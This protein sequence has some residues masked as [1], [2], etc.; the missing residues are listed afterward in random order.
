MPPR[1][2][3]AAK[4]EPVKNK[5]PAAAP[6]KKKTT[7]VAKA[8]PVRKKK[9]AEA[10]PTSVVP[11][12]AAVAGR[13]LVIVES[14]AKAKTIEKYLGRGFKVL[15]SYGHVRDLPPKGKQRGED[16]VGIT[17][18]EGWKPRYVVVDRGAKSG[19]RKFKSAQ[20]ILDELKKEADKSSVVYLA[21]DPDREGESIAWH[22]ADELKLDPKRTRRIAFN[23][24]TKTA[25]QR[26]L[27][28]PSSINDQLV[29]AQEA[30]RVL[31]RV[32]GY[33]LSNLLGKKVTRGLSA[34]RVQSVAVKLIV[35]REREIEA[36]KSEEYWKITALLSLPGTVSYTAD[37]AKAKV[38]A[39]KKG[40][41]LKKDEGKE[42]LEGEGDAPKKETAPK[43][44]AGSFLA[45]LTRWNGQE[46]AASTEEQV[47]GIYAALN[48]AA[49]VVTKVDQK[50][51]QRRAP[52]P[53]TTSTLQQSG[54]QR[55]GLSSKHTM[56]LAQELYQGVNLGSEGS[57]ALITYMRTDSTRVSADALTM[58]RDYIKT[59]YGDRYLPDKP[60]FFKSGKSAQEAHEAIRP[61]DLS[62]TPA[63]VQPY[64]SP[65]QYKLYTL[66]FNQFVAS[67]MMPAIVAVTS[68]DIEAA[69]GVLRASG[70]IEKFDGWRK[71]NP[72]AKQEDKIL[73]PLAEKQALEKLDLTASQHFTQPPPRYNEASLVKMLEKEGIGR[74]STYATIISTIQARGYVK[75]E[76]RRFF[77]SEIG[78]VVT[79]LLVAHFPDVINVKFTSHI[80]EEL[81]D[82]ENGKIAYAAVLNEFWAP[83]FKDLQ[84][85][86][87]AMPKQK[88]VETGEA[89]PKCGRMLVEQYSSKTG[90]KFVGCP[91][92][93]EKENPCKYI[94]PEEGQPERP[95]PVMT[96]FKC[97]VCEKPMIKK[98]GR[99]GEY[100]SCSGAPEC[101]TTMNIGPD[102]KPIVTSK[103]TEHICEKCGKPM[104]LKEWKGR[105][106]LGCSG[107][108][109]CRN[110]MDADAQGNPVKP[111]DT[112]INCEKCGS[113]MRVK[114]GFRGPFL[115][116]SGYPKC[117]NAKPIPAELKEKLKDLLPPAPPKKEQIQIDI[118]ERCPE[119]GSP[120]KV[121]Q[122]RGKVFL[123]CSKY[124]KCKGTLEASAEILDKVR[125]AQEAAAEKATA[126]A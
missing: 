67:Q 58:V 65:D 110:S 42:E 63:R 111:I 75:Q 48:T 99:Y 124:P 44:P 106:F 64:L 25:V 84:E 20:E 60:N 68:V 19:G 11:E 39:K 47:D 97:P 101:K 103:A 2:K 86:E 12:S 87:T 85:A 69:A 46:F 76:H 38:Y 121:R 116:C 61:T 73:P 112:G 10:A 13:S 37:P 41:H 1:K 28:N 24:I 29:Q 51:E 53:F 30:R 9:V 123:G 32:V 70:S 26:A 109:K 102:G 114:R 108:P 43:I 118:A 125:M 33:P 7:A 113:P 78:K 91:G 89:C 34:G 56:S 96:E 115:S 31:D 81:D 18:K 107:Y 79:D 27:A 119:C 45:E 88:G 5:K 93:K 59:S 57:V 94:K 72:P 100:L 54:Y 62:N 98:H 80:E 74:P 22:I 21:T 14:P 35:D 50:D 126:E 71:V 117:R 55:L 4:T 122:Y 77:A 40:E 66:I 82:I 104:I 105:Y 3:P 15:A 90:R 23:E 52:A 8:A 36:F 17:I 95:D 16:V 6:A 92:W 49:Y 83:F 120:L